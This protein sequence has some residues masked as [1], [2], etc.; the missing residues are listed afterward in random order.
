MYNAVEGPCIYT[1]SSVIP[2]C[3]ASTIMEDGKWIKHTVTMP[4]DSMSLAEIKVS[5]HGLP[6][7]HSSDAPC[8]VCLRVPTI[9]SG[10]FIRGNTVLYI[11]S[12]TGAVSIYY[13][14][15]YIITQLHDFISSLQIANNIII[16]PLP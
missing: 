12:Y 13:H 4:S 11:N 16:A 8:N 9:P 3:H 2:V 7:L 5:I 10:M 6:L 15:I 14:N 1:T